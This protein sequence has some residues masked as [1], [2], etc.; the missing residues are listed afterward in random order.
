MS[1]AI[2]V[3]NSSSDA[4]SAKAKLYKDRNAKLRK[5]DVGDTV[6]LLLPTDNNK[7]LLTWKGPFPV[8]RKV[9]DL[10]YEIDVN[11]AH[12]TFHINMLQK[13][14]DRPEYLCSMATHAG[15]G[16]HKICTA[17]VDVSDSPESGES[18][19]DPKSHGRRYYPQFDELRKG[20]CARF[21]RVFFRCAHGCPWSGICN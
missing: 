21:T 10:D 16:L 1:S 12:K 11:G 20:E 3:A 7:L 14:Y 5:F 13:F 15:S 18:K 6:L 4:A 9:S 17:V 19:P 8:L 2:Q